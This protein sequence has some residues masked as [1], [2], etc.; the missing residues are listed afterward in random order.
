MIVIIE[1]A[2]PTDLLSD[3]IKIDFI[4]MKDGVPLRDGITD[5]ALEKLKNLEVGIDNV[6]VAGYAKTGNHF[7]LQIL[8]ELG[9]KRMYGET[10][11]QGFIYIVIIP[12]RV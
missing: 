3:L 1:M 6:M 11:G 8:Q 2:S 7:L 9:Y 10:A 5:D 12:M 4:R